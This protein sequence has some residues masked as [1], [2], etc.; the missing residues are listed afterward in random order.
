MKKLFWLFLISIV[1]CGTCFA[2]KQIKRNISIYSSMNYK[3]NVAPQNDSLIFGD[4]R[5]TDSKIQNELSLNNFNQGVSQKQ[6]EIIDVKM[7]GAKGD[8]KSDDTEAIQKAIDTLAKDGGAI[9]ISPGTYR[10]SRPLI[11]KSNIQI[12]GAGH[13]ST[14]K[15]FDNANLDAVIRQENLASGGINY[16]EFSDFQIDGNVA[17]GNP[18]IYG[19]LIAAYECKFNQLEVRWCR[20]GMD[21]NLITTDTYKNLMN[22]ITNCRVHDFDVFGIRVSTD[23]MIVNCLISGAGRRLGNRDWNTS[24]IFCDGWGVQI[25]NNHLWGNLRDIY[26]SWAKSVM[27]RDNMIEAMVGEAIYVAGR[28]GDFIISNNIFHNSDI[29]NNI[30]EVSFIR[31][32]IVKGEVGVE[33]LIYNNIFVTS[34]GVSPRPYCVEESNYCDSNIIIFNR[35]TNAFTKKGIYRVGNATIVRDN[36]GIND[37]AR[38]QAKISAGSTG[39]L[40]KY[41]LEEM[42]KIQDI[43]VTPINNMGKA[44]KFWV[45]DLTNNSFKINVNTNPKGDAIFV[46][47]IN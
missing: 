42:P 24:G 13:S 8:N 25:Q 36:F 11:I 37:S 10:L 33:S 22:L 5:Q 30:P 3:A 46:W 34:E 26:V 18:N 20:Y 16:V 43:S 44:S 2:T 17:S 1:F 9:Y 41:D 6:N 19:I 45:S 15:P 29:K 40:V 7:F 12:K 23:S 14:L 28:S 47:R 31:F 38:G 35:M 21:I 39:I 32:D 27:I 4:H